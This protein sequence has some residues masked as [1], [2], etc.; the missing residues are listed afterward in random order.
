MDHD[1]ESRSH[2]AGLPPPLPRRSRLPLVLG[3]I[4]VVFAG[5]GL[6][7]CV[8][9]G[10]FINRA[11]DDGR[12][13]A[14]TSN[15][16]QIAAGVRA[17]NAAHGEL[18]ANSY[19]QEDKPLLSWRVH[20]LPHLNMGDLYKRFKLDEPWDSAHNRKLIEP[21]PSVYA[22]PKNKSPEANRLTYY[23]GFSSPMGA[24]ERK[25]AQGKLSLET[26]RDGTANTILVIEAADAIE[27]TRPEDLDSSPG[28]P[29]PRLGGSSLALFADGTVRALRHD[30]PE[31]TL[32]A[33]ST[34]SGG[35]TLPAGSDK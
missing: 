24:F 15:L 30:L 17:F 6:I 8:G 35:E 12:V 29:F 11:D 3:I 23:R 21:I 34:H 9:L 7:G 28:R 18:P 22:K 16:N 33:L 4:G 20:L 1:R 27:W 5:C 13:K 32:R 31:S 2:E 10:W 25:P 14:S 19:S 26:F